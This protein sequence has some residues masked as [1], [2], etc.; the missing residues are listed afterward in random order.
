MTQLG[1]LVLGLLATLLVVALRQATTAA[2]L[3]QRCAEATADLATWQ[4]ATHNWRAAYWQLAAT[5][6]CP[7]CG[8]HLDPEPSAPIAEPNLRSDQ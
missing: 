4:E 1:A 3:R 5:A 6:T 8:T 2:R 7:L